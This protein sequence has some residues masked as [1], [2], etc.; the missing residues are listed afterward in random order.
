LRVC[1]IAFYSHN[2]HHSRE[3]R[4]E[5]GGGG[6]VDEE[7]QGGVEGAYDCGWRMIA[8]VYNSVL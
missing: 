5:G 7:Q 3:G 1:T 6:G 8:G 4:V 2:E